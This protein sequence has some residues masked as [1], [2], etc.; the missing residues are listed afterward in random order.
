MPAL[1]ADVVDIL[2]A[3]DAWG[4]RQLLR[5]CGAL[6]GEQFHRRFEIGPGSLHD[7]ITHM[8]SAMRRWTDRLAERAVR[9]PI[10][11]IAARPDLKGDARQRTPAELLALLDEAERDLLATMRA[12]ASAQG[13]GGMVTLEWPGAK[14]EV[15]VYRFTCA[16]VIAHVATHGYHHRAQCLNMLR[17]LGAPVPGVTSGYPE[18]SAVDWQSEVESPPTIKGG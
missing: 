8:I 1:S 7:T 10:E 15:K 16:A 9:A 17:Q 2:I 3:S 18:L 12:L 6:P 4:T 11:A 14:G 13:L 5:V